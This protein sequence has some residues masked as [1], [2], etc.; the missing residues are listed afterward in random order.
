MNNAR[1]ADF[2]GRVFLPCEVIAPSLTPDS[3]TGSEFDVVLA[4]VVAPSLTPDSYTRARNTRLTKQVVAPSLTPDSYT[5]DEF[6]K[7]GCCRFRGHRPKL[8]ELSQSLSD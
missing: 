3:Y 6:Q 8:L 5:Y 7:V 1:S 4:G 2:T